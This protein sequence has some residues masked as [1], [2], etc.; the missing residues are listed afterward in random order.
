MSL[1]SA[2]CSWLA[3]EQGTQLRIGLRVV[4]REQSAERVVRP[5]LPGL[6]E[7]HPQGRHTKGCT[8]DVRNAGADVA[9]GRERLVPARIAHEGHGRSGSGRRQAPC[10]RVVLLHLPTD[11]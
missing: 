2:R 9:G 4:A 5:E 10:P 11:D 3:Y 8:L 1:A 6:M 7:L